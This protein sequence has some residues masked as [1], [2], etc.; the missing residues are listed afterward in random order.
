MEQLIQQI[1]PAITVVVLTALGGIMWKL[2]T[3]LKPLED[4]MKSTKVT[5]DE[6]EERH[7]TSDKMWTLKT[8]EFFSSKA[9]RPERKK[10]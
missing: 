6:H 4:F 7:E 10:P 9:L 1:A 2:I 3:I 8:G 5:L